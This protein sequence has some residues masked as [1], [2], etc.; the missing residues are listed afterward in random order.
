MLALSQTLF[1]GSL[2]LYNSNLAWGLHIHTGLVSR[3]YVCPKKKKKRG[4][5][6]GRIVYL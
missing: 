5:G 4:G 6:G 3:S 2:T 1:K